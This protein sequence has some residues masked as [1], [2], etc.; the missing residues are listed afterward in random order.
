MKK[1]ALSVLLLVS[2]AFAQ[3]TPSVTENGV[4]NAASY[5]RTGEAGFAVAPGSLVAIF[6]SDLASSLTSASS[7]PLSTSLAGVSVSFNNTAAPLQFVSP[8]QINAQ[9]P[10]GTPSGTVSVVVTRDGRASASRNLTVAQFSPGIFTVTGNGLGG[11]V[12]VNSDDG[13]VALPA[14]SVPG[15]NTR[16]ARIGGVIISMPTAWGRWIHP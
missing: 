9:L 6:G 5:A 1:L 8:G 7:V 4:L 3:P 15:L 14:G 11:A 13:S 16:P 10:W 2:T 12:A